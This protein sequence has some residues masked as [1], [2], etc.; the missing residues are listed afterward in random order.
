MAQLGN[1]VTNSHVV[2]RDCSAASEVDDN[3]DDNDDNV[4]FVMISH[5]ASKVSHNVD[6]E[7][8]N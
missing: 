2:S 7:M 8:I 4:D 5:T 3:G 1:H 6:F